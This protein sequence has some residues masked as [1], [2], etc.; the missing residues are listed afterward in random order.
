MVQR[1]YLKKIAAA[2][3][4]PNNTKKALLRIVQN[5]IE[6]FLL[7]HPDATEQELIR[8]FGTPDELAESYLDSLDSSEVCMQMEKTGSIK[9]V[10]ISCICAIIGI[11]LLLV[12]GIKGYLFFHYANA[13]YIHVKQY[14]PG[15]EYVVVRYHRP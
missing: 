15:E 2:L 5:D 11:L 4:C 9:K 14:T 10:L 1:T 7:E 13:E 3:T 6:A 8:Q 12:I